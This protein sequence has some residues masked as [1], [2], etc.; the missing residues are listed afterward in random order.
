VVFVF[1]GTK[2]V[3]S[4]IEKGC[5]LTLIAHLREKGC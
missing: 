1:V 4:V 5:N 2:D 3:L